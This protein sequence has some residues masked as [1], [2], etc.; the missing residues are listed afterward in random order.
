VN[1]IAKD[2]ELLDIAKDYFQFVTKFFEVTKVSAPHIY[3]SALELCPTSSIIRK[4]YYHRNITHLPKIVIG[5]PDSWDPTIAVSSK[6]DYNGPCTWSPCG[7]LIAAQTRGAVEIRDQLTLELIT[8]LQPT[9]TIRHLTG[10]LAYSPDGRSISCASDTAIIIWDIQT[11][12]VAKEVKCSAESISLVWSSD[13]RT[14]C[15][16]GSK[17]QATFFVHIYDVSSGT[18]LFS[19]AF[20][21][22]DNPHVW[23]HDESFRVMTTVRDR[24]HGDTVDILEV[25]ST[26]T[27]IQSFVLPPTKHFKGIVRSFSPTTHRISISDG[28]ELRI[29]DIRNSKCLLDTIAQSVSHCFSSDGSFF[30]TS[31]DHAV[32]VWK[33]A[34]GY[35]T[36][37]GELQ[38][39]NLRSSPLQFSPTP[40]SILGHSKD[41]LR[42][43]HLHQ[44]SLAP[45]NRGQWLVGL[46]RSGTRVATTCGRGSTI[47]IVDVLAQTPP[48]FIDVGTEIEGLVITGN[49]LLVESSQEVVA[50]LLTEEGLVDGVIGGRR[51]DRGD[52][53]WTISH[54]QRLCRFRVEGHVGVIELSWGGPLHV[55]HTETGEVFHLT[56]APRRSSD[57]WYHL[58]D[59]PRGRDH[60]RYHNLSQRNTSL[61]DSWQFSR[62]TLEEGWVKDPGGKH[63]LWVP[64]EW[65]V[66]WDPKD[67]RHDVMIQFGFIRN[68]LVLIKF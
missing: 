13:G 60:L 29:L 10:P 51:V 16:I 52:S 17:D 31:R 20:Q 14:L 25:G 49:V 23:A 47:K 58:A 28:P 5:A 36:R 44:L 22:R 8:I 18:T 68:T 37:L 61:E 9:E 7:Q 46:S 15:A 35:Y 24:Y 41:I 62:A 12:G 64:V 53:I 48:Q 55:Y 4:L 57:R 54:L 42:V 19:D 2:E 21:S 59:P 1:Q 26:L 43:L 40:S 34:S 38:C 32:Y 6:D 50:W 33:H 65:R 66:D 63:R 56:Q 11:G 3:H 27:K 30:A 67:W 45:R 39:P